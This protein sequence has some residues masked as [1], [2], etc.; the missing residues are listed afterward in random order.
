LGEKVLIHL[1]EIQREKH[2]RTIMGTKERAK[3]LE[4]NS[5]LYSNIFLRD[6]GGKGMGA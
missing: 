6:F 5:L 1:W 4:S 2:F 3:F